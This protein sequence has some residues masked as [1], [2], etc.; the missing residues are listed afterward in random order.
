MIQLEEPFKTLWRNRDAFGEVTSIEK[1]APQK[2]IFRYKEGRRTLRFEQNGQSYFLKHHQGIGWKEIFKNLLQLRFPV[3]GA[4]N[5][6]EA[7]KK[8]TAL[9]VDT[10]KPMAF[11]ERGHNPA[12]QESFLITEDLIGTISL[13]DFCRDWSRQRPSFKTKMALIRKLAGAARV[14]HGAGINHRDFYLCHFLLELAAEEKIQRG[15]IFRCY[16]I[17]LHRCQFRKQVPKRWLV[18]DLGGLLY[19]AMD[20]GLTRKDCYRFLKCYTGLPLHPILQNTLWK[21]VWVNAEKLYDKDFGR[22]P[23][24]IFK[25]L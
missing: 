25:Q 8:L 7:S 4:R 12:K 15:E 5:E 6:Y 3:L 14:M 17:D 23:K 13:E 10:L 9:G 2:N 11:G 19:S 16:L 1:Q 21:E 18:K 22:A 20:A 24:K